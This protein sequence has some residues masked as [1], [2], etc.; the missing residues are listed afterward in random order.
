MGKES[1]NE[2]SLGSIV[3]DHFIRQL[4]SECT[5][6][7]EILL[8]KQGILA[9][10]TLTEMIDSLTGPI[11][12]KNLYNF[13]KT[14]YILPISVLIKNNDDPKELG[15]INTIFNYSLPLD[16][17]KIKSKCIYLNYKILF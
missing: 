10:K 4:K 5:I 2:N 13:I 3:T 8:T 11:N 16:M 14:N 7:P 1:A 9:M 15:K 6:T 12:N 17:K